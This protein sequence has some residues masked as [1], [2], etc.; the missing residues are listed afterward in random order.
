MESDEFLKQAEREAQ[1]VDAL[2]LARYVLT[3]YDGMTV[4]GDDT[5]SS[6]LPLNFGFELQR[7]EAVLQMAG[8]DTT[9]PRHLPS[10]RLPHTDDDNPPDPSES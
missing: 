5:D 1:F 7:I 9:Q 3:I 2:L 4:L 8:V 10:R 6:G